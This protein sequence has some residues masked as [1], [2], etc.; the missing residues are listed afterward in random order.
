MGSTS[1][2]EVQSDLGRP[3]A[4]AV[5]VTLA[6]VGTLVVCAVVGTLVFASGS[7]KSATS[8]N[9]DVGRALGATGST[10]SGAPSSSSPPLT[11][12]TPNYLGMSV[13]EAEN[14]PSIDHGW[15]VSGAN[16]TCNGGATDYVVSQTPAAGTIETADGLG[17]FANVVLVGSCH[18]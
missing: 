15:T 16:E 10:G 5:V 18:N 11:A 14:A 3:A 9:Q 2:A 17:I 8:F 4:K 7:Q 1:Q 13:W 6:V 12:L